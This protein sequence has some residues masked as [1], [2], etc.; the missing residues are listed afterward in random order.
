MIKIQESIKQFYNSLF[1]PPFI[2]L[3][4]FL[5][6]SFDV[7]IFFCGIVVLTFVVGCIFC[8]HINFAIPQ[9]LMT[10]FLVTISHGPNVPHYSDYYSQTHIIVILAIYCLFIIGGLTC[11]CLRNRH[12]VRKLSQKGLLLGILIFCVAMCLNG[13]FGKQYTVNNLGYAATFLLTMLGIYVLFT[14]FCKF[15][16][17]SREWFVYCLALT[18]LLICAELLFAYVTTVQY[19]DGNVIKESVVLGWGVWTTI[20]GLLCMLMPASF[21]F[22][23]SHKHGWIGILS[24]LLQLFCILLSQSRGALLIGVAIFALC[25]I[26]LCLTGKN[27]KQ[28]RFFTVAILAIGILGIFVLREKLLSVVQNFINYGFGD[29]GRFDIWKQGWTHFVQ[30]PIFGSGF[31][32]SYINEEWKMEVV[33]YFYHNTVIQFLASCGLVGFGAYLFHRIQTV[34]LL[35]KK[36]N[37]YKTFLFFCILGLLIFCML[38]V[39]F[40]CIYPVMFYTLILI[41]IENSGEDP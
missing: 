1:Y 10:F 31:Y 18:G 22:A 25:M 28:N 5:G 30:N 36:P 24:G 40:F 37:L 29:N 21:Y 23:A 26:T 4:V 34:L 41:F 39:L 14:L 11:F 17:R 27:K 32:D 15:D 2:A 16:H 9:F 6:H 3:L 12:H 20:G 38:D 33:P 35:C 8:E 13:L 19:A 7:E